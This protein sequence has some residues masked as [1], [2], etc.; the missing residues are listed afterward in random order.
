MIAL[1]RSELLRLGTL[2]STGTYLL[3]LLG[4]CV[5]PVVLLSLAYD[6]EYQGPIDASDLG[7]CASVFQ[8]VA[9]V[10]AGGTTASEIRAGSILCSSLTVRGRSRVL[11]AFI[12]VR[13]SFIA[14][15]Y[16]LGMAL[17]IA[18]AGLLYPDGVHIDASGWSYL[19]VYLPVILTWSALALALAE[20]SRS[21]VLPI[22]GPLIWLLLVEPLLRLVPA[23]APCVLWMPAAAGERLLQS[24]L[25]ATGT[26]AQPF[27]VL[28]ALFAGSISAAFCSRLRRDVPA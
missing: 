18:A 22:A 17:A 23:L 5:G 11:T 15:A 19:T 8:M 10:F 28:G 12:V 24:L 20:L 7:K 2:R 25:L 14:A 4:A 16:A 26:S 21:S 6:P 9:I 13:L 3:V 27:V 1:T